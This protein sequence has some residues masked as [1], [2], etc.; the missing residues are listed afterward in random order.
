MLLGL[1]G[2]RP[3][4]GVRP[5]RLRADLRARPPLRQ[6]PPPRA[7]PRERLGERA[8]R[9]QPRA[10]GEPRPDARVHR[11]RGRGGPGG[12]AV[13]RPRPARHRA[14]HAGAPDHGAAPRD[15][16][17]VPLQQ[18]LRALAEVAGGPAGAGGEV[19]VPR[20]LR[21]EQLR[22]RP[23]GGGLPAAVLPPLPPSGP[24][25]AVLGP[26]DPRVAGEHDA[27]APPHRRPPR[28]VRGELP[29]D[30]DPPRGRPRAVVADGGRHP[31]RARP[32]GLRGGPRPGRVVPGRH[33]ELRQLRGGRALL[34]RGPRERDVR[35]GRRDLRRPQP[36]PPHL[37]AD[38]PDPVRRA[39][40]HV[41]GAVLLH[42]PV[43]GRP[44]RAPGADRAATGLRVIRSSR[45]RVLQPH[46]GGPVRGRPVRPPR[47]EDSGSREAGGEVAEQAQPRG[48][49]L[50]R[51]AALTF[52]PKLWPVP[53]PMG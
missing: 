8:G 45:D 30:A 49:W 36:H 25:A 24:A 44:R 1:A 33:H 10:R 2:P 46:D 14:Q 37:R 50:S 47:P 7:R 51:F 26:P 42:V 6:Q 22:V 43:H 4:A 12:L 29:H 32:G 18:L 15:R 28:A 53:S 17:G 13:A 27:D 11:L 3:R 20:A 40:P 19:H 5:R 16:D 9:L 21:R 52:Q 31:P 39:H 38:D 35:G 34:Q 48:E 23:A 41:P